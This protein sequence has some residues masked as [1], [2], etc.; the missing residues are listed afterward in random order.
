MAAEPKPGP[1]SSADR[2]PRRYVGTIPSTSGVFDHG[3]AAIMRPISLV[4]RIEPSVKVDFAVLPITPAHPPNR[5]GRQSH[6]DVGW[7]EAAWRRP[8]QTLGSVPRSGRW[9]HH[10]AASQRGDL[11]SEPSHATTA[12][13][14][15]PPRE[16]RAR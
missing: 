5:I 10:N 13:A 11:M 2:R 1:L 9:R 15:E 6:R 3:P 12:S 7:L 8:T 16:P 4:K 14:P